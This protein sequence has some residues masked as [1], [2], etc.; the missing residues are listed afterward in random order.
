MKKYIITVSL[1]LPVIFISLLILNFT[2]P[3]KKNYESGKGEIHNK[4][5][6]GFEK[7]KHSCCSS[8]EDAEEFS[9][10]SIYQLN[11]VWT[12]QQGEKFSLSLLKGKPVVLTM[13][14]ASCTYACPVLVNDMKRIESEIP[15]RDLPSYRFV[16]ISI[17][18]ERDTPQKL[19][20]YAEVKN[21]DTKRWTL[22][23]GNPDDIMELAALIGFK[24]K[25]NSNG[26][27]SHSNLITFLDSNGEIIHQ[28]IG[29][30]QD[31]SESAK[32][33]LAQN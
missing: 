1:V 25:K 5:T 21:L 27:F 6:S 28:Q 11:S 24:Y 26:D 23:T 15:K 19:A 29:L 12:D 14:F 7:E 16:L 18:P 4:V 22:L 33:L 30:N 3:D 20:R 32:I 9:D 2:A 31:I 8:E 10:N 13:F 17:D